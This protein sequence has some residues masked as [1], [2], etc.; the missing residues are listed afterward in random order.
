V[1]IEVRRSSR[2]RAGSSPVLGRVQYGT[3]CGGPTNRRKLH[4][5]ALGCWGLD[6]IPALRLV[7]PAH[8]ERVNLLVEECVGVEQNVGI[9]V[10]H[11]NMHRNAPASLTGLCARRTRTATVGLATDLQSHSAG[12]S[13]LLARRRGIATTCRSHTDGIITWAP[14]P[15]ALKF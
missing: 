8:A 7:E 13:P 1:C 5:T 2:E 3:K 15:P 9:S 4:S 12:M 11:R 14:V 10:I 6:R